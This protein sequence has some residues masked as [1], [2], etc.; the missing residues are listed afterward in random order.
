MCY[1][2][3][4]M[5]PAA[6]ALASTLAT[7]AA[8]AVRPLTPRAPEFPKGLAWLN[9]EELDLKR[10]ERRRV[11]VVSFINASSLNSLRALPALEAWWK[12]Y[13]LD[14]LMVIG[15]HTPDF[16][17]DRNPAYVRAALKRRGI[18]FPVVLDNDRAIWKSY[19]NEGWPAHY[20][21]DHKGRVIHD[22]LGEG[23]YREFE[24][25]LRE[26]LRRFNGYVPPEGLEPLADPQ[27]EGCGQAT[28]VTY[29]GQLRGKAVNLD[30]IREKQ[31]FLSGSRDGEVTYRGKWSLEPEALRLAR[32][33]PGLTDSIR[34]IYRGAEAAALLDAPGRGAKAQI[35][36]KQDDLWLHG[37]NAGK[38]VRWDLRDRSYVL[39]TEP[40][41]YQLT[42]NPTDAVHELQLYPGEAGISFHAFDFS[43]L[44]QAPGSGTPAP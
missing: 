9:S 39:V 27:A 12:R 17:A 6:L 22:R 35:F 18:R 7:T 31:R 28:P 15:V 41:L 44:C 20:L 5:T 4:V 21:I 42:V 32:N 19:A 30:G 38:D 24:T 25:E 16:E 10:L 1:S 23:G 2:G 8:F 34:L 26:A 11:T 43:N 29:L 33:N 40:R 36:V 13:S 14:G 37:K 3:I